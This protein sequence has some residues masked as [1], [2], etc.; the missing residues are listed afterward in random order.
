MPESTAD[1]GISG[2]EQA[3]FSGSDEFLT[4][5]GQARIVTTENGGDALRLSGIEVQDLPGLHVAL[6]AAEAVN[7]DTDFLGA[8]KIILGP[9]TPGS[10]EQDYP[11]PE[12][13]DAGNY[14]TVV[15][16][17]RPFGIVVAKASLQ[18]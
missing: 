7:S 4:G 18:K 8:D 5:S 3:A 10:G 6:S 11:I 14:P 2:T 15:I 16:W 1:T 17:S 9:V 13:F 12:G